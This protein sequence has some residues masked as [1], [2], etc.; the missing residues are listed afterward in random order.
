[1]AEYISKRRELIGIVGLFDVVKPRPILDIYTL[2]K[3]CSTE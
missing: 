3:L 2:S 1:M